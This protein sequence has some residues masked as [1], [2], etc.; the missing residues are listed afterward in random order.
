MKRTSHIRKK[1]T[2]KIIKDEETNDM[3][4]IVPEEL[5]ETGEFK[6]GDEIEIKS[7]RKYS[8]SIRNLSCRSIAIS[9]MCRELKTITRQLNDKYNHLERVLITKNGE[10]LFWLFSA[11][12][13]TKILNN[14]AL[15]LMGKVFEYTEVHPVRLHLL[16][17]DSGKCENTL[18]KLAIVFSN[19]FKSSTN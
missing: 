3:L 7:Y 11:D 14:E 6:V 17:R 18:N 5:I 8:L 15:E 2:S 4:W 19:Q 12:L 10:P 1:L 9:K 16:G 13:K